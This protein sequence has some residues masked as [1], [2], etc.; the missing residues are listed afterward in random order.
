MRQKLTDGDPLL[1]VLRELRPVGADALLVVEPS[2]GVR[3]GQHHRGQPLGGGVDDAMVSRSHGSPVCG[4]ACRPR[5]RRPLATAIG[6]A[7]STQF[8]TLSEVVSERVPRP[9]QS[10]G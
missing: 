5:G 7:G 8:V 2:S 10:Q 1:S 4:C 3:N 9:P 6:S